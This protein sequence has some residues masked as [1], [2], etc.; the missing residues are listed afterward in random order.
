LQPKN[1]LKLKHNG[2]SCTIALDLPAESKADDII[3]LGP[4]RC[5]GVAR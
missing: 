3:R 1:V 4:Y 2:A 5:E